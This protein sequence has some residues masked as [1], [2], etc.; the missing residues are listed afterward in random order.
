MVTPVGLVVKVTPPAWVTE[1]RLLSYWSRL[2]DPRY[3]WYHRIWSQYDSTWSYWSHR[4]CVSIW[5]RHMQRIAGHSSPTYNPAYDTLITFIVIIAA[6]S[7]YYH[8]NIL[9]LLLLLLLLLY[10]PGAHIGCRGENI[11]LH[12][13]CYHVL[14][15]LLIDAS[16]WHHYCCCCYYYYYYYILT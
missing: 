16:S 4:H 13:F 5:V 1:E 9:T 15:I 7:C 11:Y 14:I 3:D 10:S 12:P 2:T 8:Y 6:V